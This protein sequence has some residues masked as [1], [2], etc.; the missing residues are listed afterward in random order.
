MIIILSDVLFFYYEIKTLCLLLLFCF[1]KW[2]GIYFIIFIPYSD[3]KCDLSQQIVMNR[4]HW[5]LSKANRNPCSDF[6]VY[7]LCVGPTHTSWWMGNWMGRE[8]KGGHHWGHIHWSW[9]T[10]SQCPLH[11]G[12][13]LWCLMSIDV[14]V[15]SIIME[16][17]YHS[18]WF[19]YPTIILLC[20]VMMSNMRVYQNFLAHDYQI[21]RKKQCGLWSNSALFFEIFLFF[22]F[23]KCAS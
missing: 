9:W 1:L 2:G 8:I 15:Q 4:S 19:A 18:L 6:M 3:G 7:K 5:D 17:T 11:L 21:T 14:M 13:F 10:L 20:L 12:T 23:W 16:H 22:S